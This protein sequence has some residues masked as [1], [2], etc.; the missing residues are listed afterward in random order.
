MIHSARLRI[1]VITLL[2]ACAG[3]EA[4]PP[5]SP[6][7]AAAVSA[8]EAAGSP[9]AEMETLCVAT[10]NRQRECTEEFIP[11]LVDLRISLDLPAGIAESAVTEGRDALVEVARGEWAEDSKP[12]AIAATCSSMSSTMPPEQLE[13][14]AVS[15]KLCLAEADCAGFVDCI[16]PV[17]RQSM[18]GGASA[19]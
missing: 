8:E 5:R 18:T 16:I 10:F 1:S 2:T 7:P 13:R 11:A 12:E 19:P 14:L 3:A 15:A 6:Q 4:P 9:A 17:M